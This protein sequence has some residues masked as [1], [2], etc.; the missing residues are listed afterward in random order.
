MKRYQDERERMVTH[1]IARRG[2]NDERVLEA[3][4][5]VPR[6]LFIS[7]DARTAA[8]ADSPVQ[9]GSGQTISQP[10]IVALMTELLEVH[11][12][13]RVLDVGTGS[14]YQAAILG[15]LAAEVV[16]IERRPE[17]A[18]R[19]RETLESL[20]YQ[21]VKVVV[22]DGSLGYRPAAPYDRI[23]VAAAAPA[24]PQALLDQ[25]APDGRLV[26]PVG[27]R[28]SQHLEVWTRKD[29][30]FIQ[31]VDIPVIFVPLIGEEGWSG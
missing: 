3:M 26:L 21:H 7:E 12:E 17:L 8:Y 6:H 14:G 16:S 13:H 11:A 10:F 31:S 20:G 25:L 22:G 28:F 24:A 1:Q 30:Q 29:D 9:I 23:L 5:T 2:I 18:Q 27:A 19:A 4:R 15:E